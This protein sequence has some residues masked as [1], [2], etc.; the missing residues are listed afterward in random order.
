MAEEKTDKPK[1]EKNLGLQDISKGNSQYEFKKR[2][3]EEEEKKKEFDK[4]KGRIDELSKFITKKYGFVESIGLV[5]QQFNAKYEDDFGIPLEECKKGL[6]HVA[7]VVS[8]DKEKEIPKMEAEIVKF[9]KEH[10]SITEPTTED[11]DSPFKGKL[12]VTIMSRL[13]YW[14]L[15][16]DS[17]FDT[18]AAIAMSY[19]I[20]DKTNFL[21]AIRVA[22]IHKE[23]TVGKFGRYISSYV[24]AGSVVRGVGIKKTSDIDVFIVIDD[25]DVKRMSLVELKE[26][27]RSQIVGQF[28]FEASKYAGV[29]DNFLNVQVYLLTEFWESVKDANPVMFTFIRD[30]IPFYDKGAFLPWKL[31][32]KRGK[33]KPSPEAIDMYMSQGD[34]LAERVD[35][36]LLDIAIIDLYWGVLTPTQALFMLYGLA[37]PVPKHVVEETSKIFVEKEKLLEKKYIMILERII[38]IYKGYEHGKVKTIKGA[39]IDKLKDDSLEYIKRLKELRESIEKRRDENMVSGIYEDTFK[40]LRAIFGQKSQEELVKDFKLNLVKKGMVNPSL[41]KTIEDLVDF[42]KKFKQKKPATHEIEQVRKD[43]TLLINSL[44]EYSQRC[45]LNVLEKSSLK[46]SYKENGLDKFAEVI[47]VEGRTFMIKDMKTFEIVNH[48]LKEISQDE[49]DSVLSKGKMNLGQKKLSS[50][51]FAVLKKTLGDFDVVM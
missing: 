23:L 17:R 29:P 10:P 1:P 3:N 5:P 35:K 21:S 6:L 38:Q 27:L 25:T 37:P 26:R 36:Y 34:K 24:V 22:Q 11:K 48:S 13:M 7:V 9:L 39:E 42:K 51:V 45:D 2:N 50:D 44:I 46:I 41:Q 4:I 40:L 30:G 15:G 12:W 47:S 18:V 49:F 31:L 16:L 33:I 19:P 8:D 14:E 43:S 28:V 20:L 32:L